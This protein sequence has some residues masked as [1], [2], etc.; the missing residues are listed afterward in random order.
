MAFLDPACAERLRHQRVEAEKKPHPEYRDG[1]ER[2]A[3]DTGRADRFGAERADHDRVDD[4]HRDPTQLGEDHGTRQ[5]EHRP[6][7]AREPV[8]RRT[9]REIVL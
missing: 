8:T 2:V 7:L 9:H 1:D 5:R 4:P 6:K 3:A